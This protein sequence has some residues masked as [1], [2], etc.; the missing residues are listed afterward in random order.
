MARKLRICLLRLHAEEEVLDRIV[1]WVDGGGLSYAAES[2]AAERLDAYIDRATQLLERTLN[3]GLPSSAIRDAYDAVTEVNRHDITAQ[4]RAAF[5][6]MRLQVRR[7]A[8]LFIARRDAV[9]PQI[10]VKGDYV[11][12]KINVNARDITGSQIGSHNTQAIIDS[13]NQF[14][15]AHRR[16]DDLL[17]QM[18]IISESVA[19]L[20][21]ELAPQDPD[22][23][24]EVTETF[25]SFAEESAK[26]TP[27]TGTLR[28]L[29]QA[30]IGAGKKAA[31]VAVPL[32]S[33][34]A[35]VMQIFGIAAL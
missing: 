16:E 25:Q 7:K 18:K 26:E 15:D 8:E 29:G 24:K 5:D 3:Y 23:A 30:L 28:V 34:V 6:G 1:S 22:A 17:A 19:A 13:F 32:A 20:V 12:E 33:A 9:R 27:K 4:R 10:T 35:A 11:N 14:A 2:D 31:A 21:A